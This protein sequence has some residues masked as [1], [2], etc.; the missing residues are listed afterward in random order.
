MSCKELSGKGLS[1]RLPAQPDS[2]LI[3][4]RRK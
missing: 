4:Y 2:A 1:L 3:C